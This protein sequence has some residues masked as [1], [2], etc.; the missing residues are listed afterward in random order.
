VTNFEKITIPKKGATVKLDAY[1]I[2]FYRRII[3]AYEGHTLSEKNGKIFIDGKERTSYT[4][5]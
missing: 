4:L 5:R 1:N 2:A 3:T